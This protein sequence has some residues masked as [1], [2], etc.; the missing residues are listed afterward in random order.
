[1]NGHP[2]QMLMWL[3]GHDDPMH[4]GNW[5]DR[6]P[7]RELEHLEAIVVA[8]DGHFNAMYRDLGEEDV[9]R[10][11]STGRSAHY[12]GRSGRAS[13]SPGP[14]WAASAPP[15][16]RCTTPIASPPPSPSAATTA[17]S[18]AATSAAARMRPWEHFIAE[19]RSNS[20]WAENGL[21]IPMFI[22]HGTKDL[23]EE[24]SGVLI[25]RYEGAALRDEARAPRARAQ[26][27]ADDLRGPQGGALADV[28]PAAAPPARPPVQDAEHALGRRRLGPRAR[29]GVERPAG[30]RSSRASTETTASTCPPA[31]SHDLAFDRDAEQIDDAAPVDVSVGRSKLDVPGGRADRDAP[32]RRRGRRVEGRPRGARRACTSTAR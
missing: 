12:P 30:A 2:M 9:M 15:R 23:P 17:T 8:P 28:A 32:R 27:V 18:C 16:A 24:N 29:D 21:Y 19:E 11:A 25:D 4:D 22:V 20:I 5:E 3:F 13:P 31:A 1:M 7:R 14:R 10:V 6:H 26:R